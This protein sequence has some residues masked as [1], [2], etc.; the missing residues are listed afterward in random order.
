M[1]KATTHPPHSGSKNVNQTHGMNPTFKKIFPH[2]I[3]LFVFFIV[4]II[5]FKPYVFDGEVLGQQDLELAN[6]MQGEIRKYKAETGDIPLWTNAMFS[7]MPAYQILY[8]TANPLKHLFKGFLLGHAMSPP[9]PPIFLMM[10]G[11]Y[12]LMIV[13]KVDWRI[14]LFGGLSFGLATNHIILVEAG[15]MTKLVASAYMAPI[16]AGVILALR[17]RYILGGALIA[18]FVAMQVTANHVQ[19]TYYWVIILALFGLIVL[20]QKL[21]NKENLA[22]FGK[23]AA[24]IIVAGI[25]GIA[26]NAGRLWTTY[27]YSKESIR[28][29]SELTKTTEG[30]DTAGSNAGDGLSYDYAFAWS[31]GVQESFNMLIPAYRGG[32]SAKGL[33]EADDSEVTKFIRKNN[34]LLAQM[35][36]QMQQVV[37][38]RLPTQY[39]GDQPFTSG[40]VYFGAIIFL[41]FFIGLFLVTPTLRWWAIIGTVLTIMLAWGSNFAAFNYAVFDF[42]PMYNKFR[43]QTMILGITNLLVALVAFRGLQVFFEKNTTAEQRKKALIGGGGV[44]LGFMAVAA[45]LAFG[46]DFLSAQNEAILAQI[47]QRIAAPLA[48]AVAADRAAL[49]WGDFM[50]TLAFAGAAFAALWLANMKKISA[51]W[52]VVIIGLLTV[53]DLWSVDKRY[54]DYE[55]FQSKKAQVERA[56]PTA[57]DK[58]I[59]ADPDPHYRV[60]DLRDQVQGPFQNSLT[61][62][63]HKSIG[64]YHAAK[65]L[66]YQELVERYL[67]RGLSQDNLHIFNMLNMKYFITPDGKVQRNPEAYGNAWFVKNIRVVADPSAEMDALAT[68]KPKETAVIAEKYAAGLQDFNLQYDSTAVIKLTGYTPDRMTYTYSA[69]S[70]QLA[71]FSEVYY[72]E[73]KGWHLYVDGERLE[74]LTKANYILRAAK[75]PAGDH[76]LVMAFEPSAYKTGEFISV[77]SGII[78]L[79]LTL[80]GLF[81]LF[82]NNRLQDPARLP[83]KEKE[84]VK[85]PVKKT[86]SKRRKK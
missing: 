40:G 23:A 68:L 7:G 67:G 72:P 85:Q 17:K 84:A 26:S 11:F 59:M 5:Y 24:V 71:L 1:T 46:S 76:E 50:R 64:G 34:N 47:D 8:H 20:I 13:L 21:I 27:E 82:K 32:S 39:W 38:G 3:A 55:R 53:F 31:Y 43:A 77:A 66:R 12:L 18:L 48:E 69:K 16:L 44:L 30:S 45:L 37:L 73:D 51:T 70:P 54:L 49:L 33:T 86:V 57:A 25:L 14:A 52:V 36:P 75:L 78:V 42:V 79:L 2:L 4:T 41:L 22:E 74:G 62:I 28:G 63:H 60:F 35:D 56:Q 15:H 6:G 19:I 80:Y 83:E 10:A 81:L 29:Q 65:L 58:Q 61:S 9:W